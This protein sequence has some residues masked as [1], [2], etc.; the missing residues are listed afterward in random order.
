MCG[1]SDMCSQENEEESFWGLKTVK[2]TSAE[3]SEVRLK[4]MNWKGISTWVFDHEGCV[5]SRAESGLHYR[6]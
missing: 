5:W 1:L 3:P 4:A 2:R 6:I